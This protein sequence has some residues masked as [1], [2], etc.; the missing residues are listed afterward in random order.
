[1]QAK[2]RRWIGWAVTV[3]AAIAMLAGL[4]TNVG[5][6]IGT[7]GFLLIAAPAKKAGEET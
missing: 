6:V 5:V 2:T 4:D 3:A 7:V 1:M